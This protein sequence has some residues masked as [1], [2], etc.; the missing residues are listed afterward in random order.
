[1]GEHSL[2]YMPNGPTIDY[3]GDRSG[4][5]SPP[6]PARELHRE[7]VPAVELEREQVPEGGRGNSRSL[8]SSGAEERAFFV[9]S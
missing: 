6:W 9:E 8:F 7:L 4:R 2:G 5:R 1:M 3:P